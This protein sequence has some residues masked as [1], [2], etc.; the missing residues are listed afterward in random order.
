MLAK[1]EEKRETEN[2][3]IIDVNECIMA[4][5]IKFCHNNNKPS[6][7]VYELILNPFIYPLKK[8]YERIYNVGE[9]FKDF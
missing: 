3:V 7:M 4:E 6:F 9:S 8:A 2:I 5:E 1:I